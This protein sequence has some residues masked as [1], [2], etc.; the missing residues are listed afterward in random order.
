MF[1]KHSFSLNYSLDGIY[2]KMK[3]TMIFTSKQK[4]RC[5]D[6]DSF[7]PKSGHISIF[8]IDS[9]VISTYVS[10]FFSYLFYFWF[11]VHKVNRVVFALKLASDN[12][13]MEI[14]YPMVPFVVLCQAWTFGPLILLVR[15]S[16]GGQ[17]VPASFGLASAILHSDHIIQIDTY[18]TRTLTSWPCF[19]SHWFSSINGISYSKKYK[20]CM[21]KLKICSSSSK[22][23]KID[24]SK[25]K[26]WNFKKFKVDEEEVNF[27]KRRK[28]MQHNYGVSNS[29]RIPF[30]YGLARTIEHHGKA[31]A[32]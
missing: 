30:W 28:W 7:W 16:I 6:K 13:W 1:F 15:K 8:C 31:T 5:L 19:L 2:V 24:I 12:V 17:Y 20:E 27:G 14:C 32:E 9:L 26:H 18:C 3:R 11:F 25:D 4:S 23:N 10:I 21:Q 29:I 22:F